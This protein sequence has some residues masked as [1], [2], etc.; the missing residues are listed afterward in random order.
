MTT[1]APD[2]PLPWHRSCWEMLWT[3]R[4]ADRFPH[5]LLITGPAG[6]GKRRLVARLAH[7]LLCQA[8]DAVGT[9]CGQCRDC[10]LWA[11][12]NHPDYMEIGPDPEGPSDEIRVAS[13]RRLAESDALTAHR[14]GYKL[15]VIDPAQR[16]N[17]AA[18]N[19]LLK[20]L[21]EPSPGTLLCLV[22]EQ[23]SRLPAT[24]RSRCQPLPVSVPR[25][26]EAVAWLSRQVPASEA[27]KLLSVAAGAPLRALEVAQSGELAVR[28]QI[29]AGFAAVGHGKRD[30]VAT[31][32]GW[33][34]YEPA[35][36]LDWLSGWMGDL[37]RLSSGHPEP[38]LTN[39]DKSDVLRSLAGRM[40]PAA[41]HRFLRDILSAKAAE[42]ATLNRLLLY[43]SL[44][45]AWMRITSR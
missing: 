13:V 39:A 11:A 28:D 25:E 31:A 36:L 23:P 42:G 17:T 12:G 9:P 30:P 45:V 44:L 8:A 10:D 6:V 33:N 18:A 7:S 29:F 24:V 1:S 26:D 2:T 16:M 14:G 38:R 5:A 21:E 43:E 35:I 20:T 4:M 27:S 32:A 34:Q 37:L 15:I 3:A 19:S 40:D 22:C 41:G